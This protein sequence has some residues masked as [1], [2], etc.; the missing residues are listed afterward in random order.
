MVW[1]IL[2]SQ[3]CP[4]NVSREELVGRRRYSIRKII[5]SILDDG[6]FVSFDF[7]RGRENREFQ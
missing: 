1:T 6:S 3:D 7:S 2:V 4:E 5:S